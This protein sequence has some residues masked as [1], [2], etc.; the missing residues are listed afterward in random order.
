MKRENQ[1]QV[2]EFVL[3]GFSIFPDLQVGLFVVFLL[4][5]I[6]TLAGNLAI[7]II[8]RID[9]RLHTPMYLFLG[10]LS[11]SETCY[12]LVI[13]PKTLVNLVV[14]IRTISFTGCATQMFFFLGLG[15][16]NCFLLTL[17]GYDRY[18]AICH[19][20]HYASLMSRQIFIKLVAGT[21]LSGFLLS[22]VETILIFQSPFCSSNTINHFF[23]HMRP[24]IKLA[25][26]VD[27]TIET[28]IS[29][30]S[31]VGLSGSF[32]LIVLTYIFILSTILWL[33][34]ACGE[35]DKAFSTCAAHLTVVIMHFGF[36]SIIYLKPNSP[37]VS[38]DDTLIS[39][40]YTIL[41]PFLSPMIFTLRNKET[42]IALKKAIGKNIFSQK[43]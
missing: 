12:S 25:C 38:D 31:I 23:C 3:I 13:I 27:N 10:V 5:Y 18:L 15:G 30:V 17:M 39:V 11:F 34:S 36:A 8:I 9:R 41:T 43:V 26:T 35:R 29:L 19:P 2:T 20:L 16:T 42:K 40:P 33:P 22:L 21:W 14:D 28:V 4:M 7:M 24:V 6:V 32:L 1:S 37:G